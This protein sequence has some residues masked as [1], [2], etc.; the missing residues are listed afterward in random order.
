MEFGSFWASCSTGSDLE[1][2]LRRVSVDCAAMLCS[3]SAAHTTNEASAKRVNFMF[4]YR[5]GKPRG[6]RGFEG[7]LLFAHELALFTV[8]TVVRA[9]WANLYSYFAGLSAGNI[10]T[11]YRIYL[12]FK[13]KRCVY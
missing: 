9:A 2:S 12:R 8:A 13:L 7:A 10:C 3:A 5:C 1:D 6:S 11:L 4:V